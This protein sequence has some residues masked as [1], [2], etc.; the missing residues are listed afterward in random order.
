VLALSVIVMLVLL[1]LIQA[2]VTRRV[3]EGKRR[4]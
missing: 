1:F 4:A 2:W 3:N